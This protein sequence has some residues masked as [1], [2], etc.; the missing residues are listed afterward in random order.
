[1]G[2]KD[3][4]SDYENRKLFKGEYPLLY[5]IRIWLPEPLTF[6]FYYDDCEVLSTLMDKE[7]WRGYLD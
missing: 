1:M 5:V 7:S 2:L 4:F 3:H 6:G